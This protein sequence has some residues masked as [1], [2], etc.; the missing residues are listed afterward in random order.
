VSVNPYSE[1]VAATIP[2][3]GANP[4]LHRDMGCDRLVQACGGELL[5]MDNLP[6]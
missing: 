2:N 6:N 1:D 3:S 5:D 4:R